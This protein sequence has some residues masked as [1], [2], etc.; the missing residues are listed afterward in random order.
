MEDIIA[1]MVAHDI[2]SSKRHSE[3]VMKDE[4]QNIHLDS[5]SKHRK[6]FQPLII[7]GMFSIVLLSSYKK[8]KFT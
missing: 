5:N 4:T 2:A 3:Y 7:I 1:C 8:R 6:T